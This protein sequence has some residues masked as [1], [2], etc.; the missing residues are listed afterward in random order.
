M[1]NENFAL[2]SLNA[3]TRAPLP[4]RLLWPLSMAKFKHN[5]EIYTYIS[6]MHVFSICIRF[7]QWICNLNADE[8]YFR[9]IWN[10]LTC[11]MCLSPLSLEVFWLFQH[12]LVQLSLAGTVSDSSDILTGIPH[13]HQHTQTYTQITFW[14]WQLNWPAASTASCPACPLVADIK[15]SLQSLLT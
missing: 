4:A 12:Q 3:F 8:A 7:Q 13:T 15:N 14:Y 1:Q 2:F 9:I 6:Y 11:I 5:K 10:P